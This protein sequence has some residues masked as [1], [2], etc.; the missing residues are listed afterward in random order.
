MFQNYKLL[1]HFAI[2]SVFFV[3]VSTVTGG[4]LVDV[5]GVPLSITVFYFPIIYV[6]ADVLTEVYGYAAARRIVW[7]TLAARV[8]SGAI[9]YLVAIAPIS[10][11]SSAGP[12]FEQVFSQAPLIA[13]GGAL[14]IFV[15]DITNNYVL[16]KMKV[17]TK[18]K[19][20]S[21]RLVTSTVAGEL[22]NSAVFYGVGLSGVLPPDRL[23]AAIL[24]AT[25]AKTLVE[26]VLL[27]L[28]KYVI[29]KVKRIEGVDHYDR[30]TN[31]NPFK[32]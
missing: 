11:A 28:T 26:I 14:A 30:N 3:V 12:A 5:F 16:A 22:T 7:Y 17:W 8:A 19:F 29:A 18:G 25:L 9:F 27:P 10:S 32:L 21:A 20:Q 2:W 15:G 1:H 31:F 6:I 24:M 4:K 13:I 23:I